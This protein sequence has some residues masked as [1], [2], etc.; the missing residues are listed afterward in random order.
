MRYRL[1]EHTADALVEVQGKNLEERFGNAAYALFDLTTDIT[2]VEPKGEMEIVLSAESRDQ[3]LVDFLQ[4]L[5]FLHDAEDLV[6]CEFDVTTDGKKLDARVRGEKFD[7]K[8]H[9][10]RSVVKGV[11]YH[12]LEF[13]DEEGTVTILFDV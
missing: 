12:R 2:K 10:K 9:T 3:L 11:T 7:E 6:F 4:E 5:L 13:D 1:L 8:K